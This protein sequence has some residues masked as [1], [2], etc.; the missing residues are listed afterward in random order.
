M[1]R[2]V[3]LR[4]DDRQQRQPASAS[5][6]VRSWPMTRRGRLPHM[7]HAESPPLPRID[8]AVTGPLSR[9]GMSS[10]SNWIVRC[11]QLHLPLDI[12]CCCCSDMNTIQYNIRRTVASSLRHRPI[13]PLG[14]VSS[15]AHR[16]LLASSSSAMSQ[17]QKPP[18]GQ[19]KS[20][21]I[22]QR[23]SSQRLMLISPGSQAVCLV[24]QPLSRPG[25]RDIMIMHVWT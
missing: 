17:F 12:V 9:P 22:I 23:A 25:P 5:V 11:L 20:L 19:R 2:S 1:S 4:R 21:F 13:R 16:R 10:L 3:C 7:P 24:R 14:S 18:R 8:T 15:V 6:R